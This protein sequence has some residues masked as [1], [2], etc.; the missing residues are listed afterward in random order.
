MI[1]NNRYSD[2]QAPNRRNSPPHIQETNKS[3][4][5][6][7]KLVKGQPQERSRSYWDYKTIHN[8]DSLRKSTG[9]N[10]NTVI[11]DLQRETNPFL[12]GG[13]RRDKFKYMGTVYNQPQAR[14]NEYWTIQRDNACLNP[15]AR[16]HRDQ[17]LKVKALPDLYSTCKGNNV[18][19]DILREKD[20]I[21]SKP[22]MLESIAKLKEMKLLTKSYN[23]NVKGYGNKNRVRF[24]YNDYHSRQTNNGFARTSYGAFY[25]R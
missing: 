20:L 23:L 8:V 18:T 15:S 21:Q 19:E 24:T 4:S 1:Q 2:S 13:V 17:S 11:Q 22:E 9:I 5:R 12:M 3:I 14:L 10:K 7:T 6:Y 16:R 25:T